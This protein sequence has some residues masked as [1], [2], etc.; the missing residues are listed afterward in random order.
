M[1][2]LS[3]LFTKTNSRTMKR[4]QNKSKR[5]NFTKYRNHKNHKNQKNHRNHRNT[6]RRIRGGSNVVGG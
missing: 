2:L 4:T 6:K 3:F 5:R 1:N